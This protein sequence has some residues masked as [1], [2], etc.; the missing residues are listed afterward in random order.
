MVKLAPYVYATYIKDLKVQKGVPADEWY[1]FSCTPVGDGLVDNGKLVQLLADADCH[2]LLAVEIDCLHPDYEN[3]EDQVVARSVA[4]LKRLTN[5]AKTKRPL[6]VDLSPPHRLLG[7]NRR[8]RSSDGPTAPK[9]NNC[10]SQSANG[11]TVERQQS[12]TTQE[13]QEEKCR[14]HRPAFSWKPM[15]TAIRLA[16]PKRG[17]RR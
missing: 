12:A 2:D 11:S 15:S 14:Q 5:A 3:N 10:S 17:S 7:L 1:F 13:S 6:S 4:E 16:V 9:A 8:D